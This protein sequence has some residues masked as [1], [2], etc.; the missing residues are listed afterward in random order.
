MEGAQEQMR[1]KREYLGGKTWGPKWWKTASTFLKTEHP[2]AYQELL[3]V[4]DAGAPKG[5]KAVGHKGKESTGDECWVKW[6]NGQAK[7]TG[8]AV[9][10]DSIW[11]LN[12]PQRR[13][14]LAQWAS[15]Y[16]A[17]HLAAYVGAMDDYSGAMDALEALRLESKVEIVKRATVIGC[18]T[19]S[20]AKNSALLAAV[21]PTTIIVEEAAE[22]LEAHIL[23][24]LH[25]SVR[26]LV[27]IG[28]H[29][30]LRPK[31]ESY[32][33][34]KESGKGVD[35]DESLFERL[36]LQDG[37]PIQ[38]LLPSVMYCTAL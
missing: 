18:T 27:L 23:T 5:M 11:A 33:L 2:E 17:P 30:Q 16:R 10:A 20:A 24:N 4:R 12:T 38:V 21:Q 15:E 34:R 1:A 9:P 26:R 28:D 19:T 29:K 25:P 31:L 22:I 8:G 35:F 37:F 3:P 7:G 13:G 32:E 6:C 36:A 14:L